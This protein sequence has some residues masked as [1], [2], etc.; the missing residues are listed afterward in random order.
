MILLSLDMIIKVLFSWKLIW[1]LIFYMK[2]LSLLRY[3]LEIEVAL[4]PK[5][6]SLSQ[7]RY[8]TDLLE[9]TDTLWP[10]PIDTPIDPNIHFY[11]NLGEPLVDPEKYT[12][13]IGKLI[14]LIVTRLDI[15]FTVGVL[16]RYMRILYQLHWTTACRILWYILKGLQVM[17]CIIALHLI[18][19]MLIGLVILL[20]IILLVIIVF[21][22]G[23]NWWHDN[24]KKCCSIQC[25]GWV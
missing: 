24:V 18:W 21:F 25:W 6:F 20:I 1:V 14:C 4:S 23:G 8:L 7:R 16:S 2:D 15:T 17:G 12:R 10:R 13:L 3:F 22:F 19:I 11:Q 9:E 5:G